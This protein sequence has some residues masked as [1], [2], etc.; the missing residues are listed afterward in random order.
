[1]ASVFLDGKWVSPIAGEEVLRGRGGCRSLLLKL[2]LI[3]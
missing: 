3:V 1:M 2:L